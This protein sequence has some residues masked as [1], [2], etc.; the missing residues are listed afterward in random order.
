MS[1][2]D[3]DED[4]WGDDDA[5]QEALLSLPDPSTH[6]PSSNIPVSS[7]TTTT[8]TET[9]ASPARRTPQHSDNR[10]SPV[11]PSFTLKEGDVK[12]DGSARDG[13]VVQW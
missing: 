2:G 8:V 9:Q 6:F 11:K 13:E 5:F 10:S 4:L 1:T 3:D 7:S 12:M